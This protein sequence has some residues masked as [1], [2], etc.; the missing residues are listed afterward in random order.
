LPYAEGEGEKL[1]VN[2]NI[3]DSITSQK[4]QPAIYDKTM[5]LFALTHLNYQSAS[6]ISIIKFI[7]LKLMIE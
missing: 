4:H 3:N 1:Q 7:Y 6:I 2:S 5:K